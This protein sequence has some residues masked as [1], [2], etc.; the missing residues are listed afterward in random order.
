VQDQQKLTFID[1]GDSEP[2]GAWVHHTTGTTVYCPSEITHL[3]KKGYSIE[4]ADIYSPGISIMVI[5]FQDLPF[6]RID[7]D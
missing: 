1:I 3:A 6:T 7:R 2:V 5:L 4:K